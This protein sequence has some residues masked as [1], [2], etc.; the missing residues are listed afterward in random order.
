MC[1]FNLQCKT[2]KEFDALFTSKQFGYA[3]VDDYY[4]DATLHDKLHK[5]T[6]PTL[7]LSA[8]DDPFQPLEAIPIKAAE[9]CSH[10]AIVVTARG[11][12]IGFLEGWWPSSKEQYM[13]RLFAEFFLNALCNKRTEFQDVTDKMFDDYKQTKDVKN[14]DED[15]ETH[16]DGKVRQTM[17]MKISSSFLNSEQLEEI[18]KKTSTDM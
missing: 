18:M 9:E 7:C 15:E 2:I 6:V 17:G 11:G 14:C 13:S 3:H 10:V 8:A 12:H 1:L 5:I 16:D 4:T